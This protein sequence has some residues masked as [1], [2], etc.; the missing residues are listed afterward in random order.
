MKPGQERKLSG[1]AAMVMFATLLSRITGFLRN[2]L[3]KAIMSPK[4]YSDSYHGFRPAG[5]G[6]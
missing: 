5:F 6:F 2:V 1:T 4:G 3:I